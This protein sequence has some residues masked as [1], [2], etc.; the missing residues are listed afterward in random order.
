MLPA[1]PSVL[2]GGDQANSSYL[3]QGEQLL[4]TKLFVPSPGPNRVSRPRLIAQLNTSLEKALTLISAPAGYGKT[5]LVSSW[6]RE[7]E[8]PFAWISLDEADNDPIRFL[9]Y[10]ILALQKIVPA[11]RLDLLGVLQRVQKDT[12]KPLLNI[13][14]N[15]IVRQATSFVLILDDFHTIHAQPVL[16]MTSYLFEH[17]PPQLHVTLLSRTDPPFP[18]SHLRARNQLVDIRADHLRFTRDEICY[19]FKKIVGLELSIAEIAAMESRTEGWIAGLQLAAISMHGIDDIQGFITAFTG[20][21]HYIMDYLSEEVLKRQPERVRLFLLQT[22]ILRSMCGPLCQAVVDPYVIEQTNAQVILEDLE[23]MNLFLIP[24]DDK[25]RWYRY[26]HLFAE[27]L[28]RHLEHLYPHLPAQLHRRASDWHEQNGM[29]A[30]ATHHAIMGGNQARAAQLVEQNGCSL[31]MRGEGFTLLQWVE[32]VAPFTQKHPWLSVLKAWGLALTGHLDQVEPTLQ[33]AEGLFSPFEPALE[34]KIM[35]GSIA[36]VRAFIANL[37][38]EAQLAEDYAQGALEYLPLSNDFSCSMRS[39]ATSICG[40]ACWI[41]GNLEQARGAY[42]EAVQISQVAGNIYMTMIAKS[43]LADVLIEQGELHQAARIYAETLQNAR[44]PDGQELPIAD[45]LFAGL[46][47]I[48][49]EWNHLQA[50][51]QHTQRCIELCQQWG[52]SN[53]LAKS[54]VT[55]AWLEQAKSNPQKAR[56]A[57]RAAELMLREQR[58]SPRQSNII[59]LDLAHWW[60][61]QGSLD[62]ASHLV[63]HLELTIDDEFSYAREPEYL[64]LLR[65]LLAQGEYDAARTLAERFLHMAEASKRVGRVIEILVLQALIFQGKKDINQALA[66]LEKAFSLAQP[67]G[68]ARIFLDEG[69]PMVKLLYQA[70]SRRLGGEY[71]SELLSRLFSAS[72]TEP[73]PSQLLIEPL[74]ARELELLKLI[75]AGFTNQEIAHWLVISIPTVKRHISNIYAKLGAK[76]RTQAVSLGRELKLFE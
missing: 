4:S 71:P 67:E 70:K 61:A 14:I 53:L 17:I 63:Q 6:L 73:T 2:E 19:F 24:L 22:S 23:R 47:G 54:Y 56:G 46:G 18:L 16:E 1:G 15:E 31:L 76:S 11:L 55:Q 12:F 20:S 44:H 58:L 62:R 3:E 30:E 26:H 28:N 33:M 8:L 50:A 64:L 45:R 35:L 43:N 27:V 69:E 59:K 7:I 51:G 9:Q 57:M 42:L 38:G 39:V 60:I 66:I 34:V 52:N 10:L 21:H 65:L 40:D 25:R 13:I 49:Y 68:Y 41:N 72:D 32:S 36:A 74:T 48:Y 75:E 37:H 29:I 5:T